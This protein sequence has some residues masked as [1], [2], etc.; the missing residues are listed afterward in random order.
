MTSRRQ[1]LD[2]S[3]PYR[4]MMQPASKHN[5]FMSLLLTSSKIVFWAGALR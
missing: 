4:V 2:V 5:I 1:R 3:V